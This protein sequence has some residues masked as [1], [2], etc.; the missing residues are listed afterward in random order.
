MRGRGRKGGRER[1]ERRKGGREGGRKEGRFLGLGVLVA[2]GVTSFLVPLTGRAW[3]YMYVYL[4]MHSHTSVFVNLPAHIY[5]AIHHL[6]V[7]LSV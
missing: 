6:F 3:K 7:C 5:L 2:V 4:P 1:E